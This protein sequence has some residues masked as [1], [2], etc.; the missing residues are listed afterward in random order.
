MTRTISL[1]CAG[2]LGASMMAAQADNEPAIPSCSESYGVVALQEAG[3]GGLWEQYDL[4]NPEALIKH[5]VNESGCFTLVDRGAGLE[6][7]MNERELNESGELQVRSNV[8]AGQLVAADYF[9]V[10]D[11]VTSDD[12]AGGRRIGG[13][14]GGQIGGSLGGILGDVKTKKLEADTIL[15]LVNARTGVQEATARGTA[16]KR[17]LSFDAAGLVGAAAGISS[18]QDSEIGRVIAAAYATA[19]GDLV[20]R[21]QASGGAAAGADAPRQAFVV[22]LDTDLYIQPERGDAVRA[23]REGMRVFPTGN[24]NGAFLEVQDKFGIT[25][26]V[27]VEDLL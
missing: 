10:P 4:E 21:V 11:L 16:T 6:M 8:G 2:A 23:L 24:R 26:W 19:Y 17:D 3:G 18:Y 22:A 7:G 12:D 13:I 27:S 14:I 20:A 9:L 1:I 5:Y 15:T 25:G